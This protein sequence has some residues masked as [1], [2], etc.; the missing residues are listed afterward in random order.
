MEQALKCYI[1]KYGSIKSR[2]VN[3]KLLWNGLDKIKVN[4]FNFSYEK[5]LMND[6]DE[7]IKDDF[8]IKINR[9]LLK[10]KDQK[11]FEIQDD[12]HDL[13]KLNREYHKR[14][15]THID[16]YFSNSQHNSMHNSLHNKNR[17]IDVNSL[18]CSN[19][20]ISKNNNSQ[21]YVAGDISKIVIE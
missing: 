5:L 19:L 7:R 8:Y 3:E 6:N 12:D 11:S 10:Y 2:T 16:E 13:I 14:L 9:E 4:R 18:D 1:E 15:K 17:S 20:N 21:H